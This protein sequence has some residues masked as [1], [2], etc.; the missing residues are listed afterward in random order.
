MIR[1]KNY[2]LLNREEKL[3]RISNLQASRLT[4]KK[5]AKKKRVT[6]KS[7]KPKKL[8]RPKFFSD[9]IEKMFDSMPEDVKQFVMKG[10]KR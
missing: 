2:T 6:K 10:G 5:K 8:R 3:R 4:L 7:K 1:T 9:K